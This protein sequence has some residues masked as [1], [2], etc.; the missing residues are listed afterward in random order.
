AAAEAAAAEAAAAEAAA[1]EAAA[2]EAAAAEAAAAVPLDEYDEPTEAI[3]SGAF[4][5]DPEHRVQN[6]YDEPTSDEPLSHYEV[7]DLISDVVPEVDEIS[8]LNTDEEQS[9]APSI[10]EEIQP[11][12]TMDEDVESVSGTSI[13]LHDSVEPVHISQDAQVTAATVP[14]VTTQGP[15]S[16]PIA[17]AVAPS[18]PAVSDDSSKTMPALVIAAVGLIGIVGWL[19]FAP[20]AEQTKPSSTV[21]TTS[22]KTSAPPTVQVAA[23]PQA[24]PVS[25]TTSKVAANTQK[26]VEIVP[27]EKAVPKSVPVNKAATAKTA[28]RVRGAAP[29]RRDEERPVGKPV[30]TKSGGKKRAASAKS[31][32]SESKSKGKTSLLAALQMDEEDDSLDVTKLG[33]MEGAR[34]DKTK[35]RNSGSRADR[36][37]NGNALEQLERKKADTLDASKLDVT[38]TRSRLLDLPDQDGMGGGGGEFPREDVNRIFNRES[39]AVSDCYKRHLT[40]GGRPFRRNVVLSFRVASN[41][42]ASGVTIG[43]KYRRTYMKKCLSR[44]V[45]RLKFPPFEGKSETVEFPLKIATR[46]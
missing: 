20:S 7:L 24:E 25:Q 1:A 29:E 35:Q 41:G 36:L 42:T 17:D 34:L 5:L 37:M 22:T 6:D 15:V 4:L 2:A 33:P 28:G 14:E 43:S 19:A 39:R 10:V 13:E 16:T 12:E 30:V 40:K 23:K 45:G 38:T 46:Y 21:T 8:T 9:A 18:K 11:L 3:A 31:S 26:T 27:E 32:N 44:L